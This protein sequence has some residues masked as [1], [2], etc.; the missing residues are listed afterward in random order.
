MAA[1]LSTMLLGA[2]A[3]IPAIHAASVTAPA[4][5]QAADANA[6]FVS[7]PIKRGDHSSRTLS[8]RQA[9]ASLVNEQDTSYLIEC[10][11]L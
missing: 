3:A 8:G 11:Y 7:F 6:G 2:L 9:S 1:K 10:E 4:P 5:R